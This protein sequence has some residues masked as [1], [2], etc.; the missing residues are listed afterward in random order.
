MPAGLGWGGWQG[1][2]PPSAARVPLAV[3][4]AGLPWCST[5]VL[6]AMSLPS[7]C[8]PKGVQLNKGFRNIFSSCSHSD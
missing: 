4:G 6:D 2:E 5:V 1:T 3:G 8:R 7:A